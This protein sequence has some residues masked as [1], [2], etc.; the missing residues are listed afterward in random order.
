MKG[1][2]RPILDCMP[3]LTIF[4]ILPGLRDKYVRDADKLG[5][6]EQLSHRC[7]KIRALTEPLNENIKGFYALYGNRRQSSFTTMS[8]AEMWN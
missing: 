1:R 8:F 2:P 5:L 7:R 6:D 4:L 3:H